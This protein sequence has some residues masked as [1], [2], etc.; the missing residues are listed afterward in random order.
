MG[1]LRV[2]SKKRAAGS[3]RKSSCGVGQT[4]AIAAAWLPARK[5]RSGEIA[6]AERMSKAA[7]RVMGVPMI[8]LLSNRAQATGRARLRR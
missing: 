7:G 4:R 8:H 1:Q 3:A 5:A 2:R 6:G